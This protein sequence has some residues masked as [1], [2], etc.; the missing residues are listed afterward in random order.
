MDK[1]E[2]KTKP[3]IHFKCI[4]GR[5]FQPSGFI[6]NY[7]RFDPNNAVNVSGSRHIAEND[8]KYQ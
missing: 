4:H 6:C 2:Y 3:F 5:E 1:S 7:P 8:D